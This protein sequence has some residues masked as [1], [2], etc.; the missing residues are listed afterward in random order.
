VKP[1]RLA[2]LASGQGTNL[3]NIHQQI[4]SGELPGVELALVVSNNSSSGAMEYARAHGIATE[5]ISAVRQGSQD[6]ADEALLKTLR[7][8]MIDFVVLAGYMKKIPSSVVREFTGRIINVH[9]A[10]LPAFGGEGMYGIRVHSAVIESGER[11]SGATAHLV[12]EHYDEG[13]IILQESCEVHADDTAETLSERVREI[14]FRLL[15]RAIKLLAEKLERK[16]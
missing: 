7:E 3:Q 12:S 15:P 8:H 2:I 5:H 13:P 11:Y 14:E 1:L 4:M 6:A 10:L 16:S 9:P